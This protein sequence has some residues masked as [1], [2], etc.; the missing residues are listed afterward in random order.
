MTTL[1]AI[2]RAITPGQS[3][4]FTVTRGRSRERK[5]FLQKRETAGQ[6][7]SDLRFL[8]WPGAGS[9]RRTSDFQDLER[10]PRGPSA[11][12]FVLSS[13]PVGLVVST[14]HEVAVS[15][16]VSRIGLRVTL[17]CSRTRWRNLG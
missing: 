13:G 17:A 9:N 15:K 3:G 2:T 5:P 10:G 6:T 1:T 16:S 14:L 7:R 12:G 8:W 4:V 11:Y